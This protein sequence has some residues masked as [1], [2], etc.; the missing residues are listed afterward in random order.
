MDARHSRVQRSGRRVTLTVY[1]I[2][3]S[4]R[5]T[6]S[7]H[8]GRKTVHLRV[9]SDRDGTIALTAKLSPGRW[10]LTIQYTPANG[11]TGPGPTRL[12]VKIP[13]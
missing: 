3:D 1:I 10:T 6:V 12:Q 9:K 11:F 2:P 13:A 8:D 4:G 7:A 5:V